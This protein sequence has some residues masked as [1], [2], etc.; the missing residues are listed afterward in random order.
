M[1]VDR[2]TE[3]QILLCMTAL[4]TELWH[5]KSMFTLQLW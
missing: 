2:K 4:A 5:D 3:R 1:E